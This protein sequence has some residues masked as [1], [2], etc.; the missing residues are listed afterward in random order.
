MIKQ[1]KI[2]GEKNKYLNKILAMLP[3]FIL[4][5]SMIILHR[6]EKMQIGDDHWFQQT[7]SNYAFLDYVKWRYYIWSGRV[8]AESV[9]YFIFKDGG[10]LWKF[11]NPVII[12]L[13]AYAISRIVIGNKIYKDKKSIILNC[14]ICSGWLFISNAVLHSS[15]LWITGS[16]NYIWPMTAGLLA[17][18]PFRDALMKEYSG[19]LN[20]LYLLAAV[21]ASFGQEQVTLVIVGFSIIINIHIFIR[22]KKVY[23]YLI[24]QNII[25]IIGALVILLAPGNFNRNHAEMNNWLPNYPLYSKWE[26]GFYGMQWL[27]NNLLND[28]RIMFMLLIAILSIALYKKNKGIVTKKISILI[29]IIGCFI[30][31]AGILFSLNITIPQQFIGKIKFPSIYNNIWG[32]LNSIFF[33]FSMPFSIRSKSVLKFFLWPVIILLVP[34]FIAYL[35]D[36]KTKG[37]YIALIYIAG[38]CTAV[39]M[40]V[41]PTIYASGQRTLF[42]LSTLFFIVFISL[43]KNEE[44]LLNKKYLGV[45]LIIPIIKYIYLISFLLHLK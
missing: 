2:Q 34:Y 12:T 44:W 26:I 7:T 16:I 13:F 17:T 43:L 21:F 35:Y 23:K 39:I 14:Y 42:V 41:S 19:K 33:N 45:F 20:V 1:C 30:I 25:M 9:L 29:P 11:I 4:L 6:F 27:L 38:I 8:S 32:H 40:F 15:I 10:F 36:F 22:D 3:F 28:C 18:I 37:F 24:F 31:I 5:I